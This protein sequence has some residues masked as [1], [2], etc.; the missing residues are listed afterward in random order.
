MSQDPVQTFGS[1]ESLHTD[2]ILV[3]APAGLAS[4]LRQDFLNLINGDTGSSG[5]STPLAMESPNIDFL[6]QA[7]ASYQNS[8]VFGKFLS[9]IGSSLEDFTAFQK[10]IL[11]NNSDPSSLDFL[12]NNTEFP[13]LNRDTP[14]EDSAE[15][16]QGGKDKNASRLSWK[17]AVNKI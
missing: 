1:S 7:L 8:L 2:D 15:S 6:P 14:A 12:K 4:C 3:D 17:S 5:I 16:T 9:T 10:D 13:S 11:A